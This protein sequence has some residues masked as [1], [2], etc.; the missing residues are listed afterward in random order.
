[1]YNLF[2]EVPILAEFARPFSVVF[3]SHFAFTM[4]S[5]WCNVRA[6]TAEDLTLSSVIAA[7]THKKYFHVFRYMY[8]RIISI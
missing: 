8:I 7:Y 6:L 1:M 2:I 5:C 4:S 3:I